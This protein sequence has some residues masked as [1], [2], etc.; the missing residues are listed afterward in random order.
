MKIKK[1][2]IVL[3]VSEVRDAFVQWFPAFSESLA[4]TILEGLCDPKVAFENGNIAVSAVKPM[5]FDSSCTIKLWLKPFVADGGRRLGVRIERLSAGVLGFGWLGGLIVKIAA[6]QLRQFWGVSAEGR[7]LL[8]DVASCDFGCGIQ[9]G[10]RVTAC[11]VRGREIEIAVESDF[12]RMKSDVDDKCP[13]M[14]KL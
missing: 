2:D 11:D 1:C 7:S 4:G 8:L 10:G 6:K 3:N 5:P 12:D 13:V 9:I 14:A